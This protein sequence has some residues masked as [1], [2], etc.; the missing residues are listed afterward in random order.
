ML[1]SDDANRRAGACAALGHLGPR[2]G[3]AVP[4]LATALRDE[5]PE[6]RIAASYAL[7]RIDGP[8]RRAVP[9]MLRAILATEE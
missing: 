9:E 1:E 2:A 4:A 3:A 5:A 6:V 7:A 8:A